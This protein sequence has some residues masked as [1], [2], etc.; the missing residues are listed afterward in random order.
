LARLAAGR[1]RRSLAEVSWNF[2]GE[3]IERFGREQRYLE[4]S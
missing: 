2:L 3:A 4:T 1:G